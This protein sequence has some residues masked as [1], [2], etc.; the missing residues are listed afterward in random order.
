MNRQFQARVVSK[1]MNDRL[2]LVEAL[3]EN[4]DTR[5]HKDHNRYQLTEKLTKKDCPICQAM[6]LL[7]RLEREVFDER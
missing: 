2:A 1:L 6:A 4:I 5:P 3:T 7:K